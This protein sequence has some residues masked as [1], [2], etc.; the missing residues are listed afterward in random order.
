MI[1]GSNF[2]ELIDFY[3]AGN[4]RLFGYVDV[5]KS[6]NALCAVFHHNMG[7]VYVGAYFESGIWAGED[8]DVI[9]FRYEIVAKIRES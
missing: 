2:L 1:S 3:I 5:G 4:V 8:W 7:M 6:P 9:V